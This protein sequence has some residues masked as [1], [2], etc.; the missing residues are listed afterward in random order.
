[1]RMVTFLVLGILSVGVA[2]DGHS[3]NEPDVAARAEFARINTP[4]S[5]TAT[6]VSASEI[7][8]SWPKG[9]S[10]VDGF[11]LFRSITGETGTFTQLVSVASTV[12]TYANASLSASTEYCYQVR[13]YRVIGRNTTYSDFSTIACATTPA[14]PPPPVAAPSGENAVPVH[15][16]YFLDAYNSYVTITAYF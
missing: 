3:P 15:E 6:A 5:L 16:D 7:D 4:S 14:P 11:Q 12:T 13:S 2:C 8:L 9:T 1:M 10:Q